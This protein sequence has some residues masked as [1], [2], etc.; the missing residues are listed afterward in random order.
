MKKL[1]DMLDMV[2]QTREENRADKL[3]S[4]LESEGL[5]DFSD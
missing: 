1:L 5:I 3:V 4:K 2:R